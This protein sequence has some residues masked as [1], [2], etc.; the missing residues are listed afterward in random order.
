[1]QR[2]FAL[3]LT[4]TNLLILAL[5]L[6]ACGG[7][8]GSSSQPPPSSQPGDYAPSVRQFNNP[9]LQRMNNI[10]SYANHASIY[11]LSIFQNSLDKIWTQQQLSKIKAEENKYDQGDTYGNDIV[12]Y[13][14]Y[15]DLEKYYLDMIIGQYSVGVLEDDNGIFYAGSVGQINR[16]KP[17][18]YNE[19]YYLKYEGITT[20]YNRNNDYFSDGII[21]LIITYNGFGH[22]AYSEVKLDNGLNRIWEDMSIYEGS[23]TDDSSNDYP[24]FRGF[25][26]GPNQEE[27]AGFYTIEQWL[28]TYVATNE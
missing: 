17:N 1:M 27:V 4:A 13:H 10:V 9:D 16:N 2:D 12:N 28:G 24:T 18:L 20:S 21:E 23:F 8:S 7:S 26:Y 25:F 3:I 5:G 14:N 19:D 11:G 6:S 22:R 15:D